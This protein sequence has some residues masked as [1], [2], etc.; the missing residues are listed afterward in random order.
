MP[1]DFDGEFMR[2]GEWLEGPIYQDIIGM[3]AARQ[4]W[5]DFQD[6]VD[7]AQRNALRT[8]GTFNSWLSRSYAATQ[9]V[10]LR[11]QAEVRNDVVS[12]GRLLDRMARYPAIVSRERYMADVENGL[13]KLA[14]E[15]FE[16]FAIPGADILNPAI[17]AQDLEDLIARTAHV[18]R[19]VNKAVAHWDDGAH[20]YGNMGL[21]FGHLHELVDF[22]FGLL[23]K[24][25]Q[26]VRR[27]TII[28]EVAMDPWQEAFRVAWLPPADD[29]D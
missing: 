18:R 8:F 29:M 9:A 1:I 16:A 15:W 3:V 17:P 26:I 23:N 14:T 24:Y 13:Q 12:L 25:S 20:R 5:Q 7:E 11:R 22:V 28:G 4:I 10:G 19:W 2:W 27:T 6:L 21:T